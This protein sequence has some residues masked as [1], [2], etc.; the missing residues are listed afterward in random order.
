MHSR[1]RAAHRSIRP[2][3]PHWPASDNLPYHRVPCGRDLTLLKCERLPGVRLHA[4]EHQSP[5][6]LLLY[7]YPTLTEGESAAS[8]PGPALPS[9]LSGTAVPPA[10]VAEPAR[11][12]PTVDLQD[13]RSRS[14]TLQAEVRMA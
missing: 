4:P 5:G 6:K 2:S 8:P 9:G 13:N 7:A 3:L 11:L 12:E 1:L 14:M 10:A